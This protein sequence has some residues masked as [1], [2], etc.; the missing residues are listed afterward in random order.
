MVSS[1]CCRCKFFLPSQRHGRLP[2]VTARYTSASDLGIE[3]CAVQSTFAIIYL[4]T[5]TQ[6]HCC[7][8]RFAGEHFSAPTPCCQVTFEKYIGF[9][10]IA[11]K[12]TKLIIH[13]ASISNDASI[14]NQLPRR[15]YN[16]ETHRPHQQNRLIQ[17]KPSAMPR[18]PNASGST[19]RSA[20]TGATWEVI[21]GQTTVYHQPHRSNN[22]VTFIVRASSGSYRW[23]RYRYNLSCNCSAHIGHFASDLRFVIDFNCGSPTRDA[24]R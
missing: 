1:P 19:S 20:F 22:L 10:N 16:R 7:Q 6:R 18:T 2:P 9:R 4:I 8:L 14:F 11:F 3:Q 21:T 5:R 12:Q 13:K 24:N 15:G 23:F 17:Q